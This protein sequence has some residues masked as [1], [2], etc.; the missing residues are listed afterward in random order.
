[1]EFFHWKIFRGLGICVIFFCLK[2]FLGGWLQCSALEGDG[3]R[4]ITQCCFGLEWVSMG[5]AWQWWMACS[6]S[7]LNCTNLAA[8]G[9]LW[10]H[11]CSHLHGSRDSTNQGRGDS[12]QCIT[13][14]ILFNKILAMSHEMM[15]SADISIMSPHIVAETLCDLSMLTQVAI[16]ESA[17]RVLIKASIIY[18][19]LG[20]EK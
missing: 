5:P 13:L 14:W 18:S 8:V 7:R 4:G 2:P 10:R 3:E 12:P 16:D 15:I 11:H 9:N 1:M 19:Y 17:R 20:S 6:S